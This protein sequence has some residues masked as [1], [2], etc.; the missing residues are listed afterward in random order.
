[1]L[2]FDGKKEA[3]KILQDLKNEIKKAKK[4]GTRPSLAVISVGRNLASE[5]FIKNKK[6]A[7]KKIG[8]K[9]IEYRFLV[10]VQEKEI[11]GKIRQ[12]NKDPDITGMIV[13]LPLSKN[14]NFGKIIEEI[15]PE[16]DVDGFGKKTEFQPP[17]ISA[18][19]TALEEIEGNIQEK[20]ILAVV[21]SDIFGV[22]L[23]KFLTLKGLKVN[24]LLSEDIFNK[25]NII[26]KADV[27]ITALGTPKFI[28]GDMVKEGVMLIDA[29]IIV[30]GFGKV[31]GDVDKESVFEKA[32]F[33]TPVPGGIGPLTVAF[34]LKNVYLSYE[35]IKHSK[36]N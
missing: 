13:Q 36:N 7:A 9:I 27:V 2:I 35:Q 11:I 5:L 28:K 32:A 23:K 25:K 26:Q 3:E 14:L 21:N 16:K 29:G 34:L 17:L 33:L 30:S 18:I 12:L 20:E 15:A 10:A 22:T 24:Y 19:L 8:I 1:M 4:E 6:I 31:I